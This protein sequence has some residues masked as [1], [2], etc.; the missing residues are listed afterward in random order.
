M[1]QGTLWHHYAHSSERLTQPLVR[2]SSEL[3]W[4]SWDEALEIVA[5]RFH[6]AG[7]GLLTIA[8][9]RI[10]NEDL[11]NL[12]QLTGAVGGKTALYTHMA[13]GDLVAQVGLGQGSNISEMGPETAILVVACDLEEEAPLWWLRVKQAAQRGAKLIVANPRPTKT[14]RYATH[15]LRYPYGAEAAAVL[16][17]VNSLSAKRPELPDAVNDLLRSPELQAAAK[18]FAEAQNAVVF[19]GSEGTGSGA[20]AAAGASLRQ[21]AGRHEP[22]WPAKQRPGG[23]MAASQRPGRLGHGLPAAR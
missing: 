15:I 2:R 7:D 12:R 16:A 17:M 21:S 13:G 22:H 20:V 9:G 18:V 5:A 14:E 19:F 23:R 6:E 3:V 8:S 4:S 11:F 1:R 10:S